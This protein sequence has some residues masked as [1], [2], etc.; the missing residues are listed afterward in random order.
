MKLTGEQSGRAT[1]ARRI[2]LEELRERE[3]EREREPKLNRFRMISGIASLLPSV[4]NTDIEQSIG[5]LAR[6]INRSRERELSKTEL[7]QAITHRVRMTEKSK[8][9]SNRAANIRGR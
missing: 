1:S 6:A 7:I 2:L 4:H 8:E 9:N 5:Q 3:R